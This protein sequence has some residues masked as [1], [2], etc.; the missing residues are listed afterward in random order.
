[1]KTLLIP[2][3]YSPCAQN[4][5]HYGI[6]IA[7]MINAKIHLCHAIPIPE[8]TPE[9]GMVAWPLKDYKTTKDEAYENLRS[10]IKE[11]KEGID[12]NLEITFSTELTPIKQLVSE[13]ISKLK[14]DLMLLGMS[15][16]GNV[17]RFFLGSTS[18]D[19]I[20]NTSVPVLLLPK[21]SKY[22]PLKKI[23]FATD[24]SKS[25]INS[26]HA[27]ARLFSVYSPEILLTH[28]SGHSEDMRNPN[29]L[30]NV[31]LSEVT[32]KIN[33]SKIYFRHII[34]EHVDEGLVWLTAHAQINMLCMIHRQKHNLFS[35]LLKGSHTKKI[36]KM[37]EIPLLVMP[38]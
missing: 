26:I 4:A 35:D 15:G 25:D 23:A 33:Y 7:K 12:F 28:V 6:E 34:E 16:M 37:I 24:L 38:E 2:I 29:S 19:L 8:F 22:I 1:M 3:D 11:L 32:S 10:Y 17:E 21:H 18:R 20:E 5:V 14:P 36:A 13:L 31:F 27:L 9:P 30:S